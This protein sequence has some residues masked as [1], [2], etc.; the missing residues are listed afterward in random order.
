[1]ILLF[2][3][4]KITPCEAFKKEVKFAL[5]FS[6]K[7]KPAI[8][9]EASEISSSSSSSSASTPDSMKIKSRSASG[10]SKKLLNNLRGSVT[11]DCI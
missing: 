3:F 8:L 1:M 10:H 4:F 11:N 7:K 2:F 9:P 5:S 6:V